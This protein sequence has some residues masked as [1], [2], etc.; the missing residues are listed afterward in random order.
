M[1]C[2]NSLSRVLGPFNRSEPPRYED[3]CSDRRV[4][5]CELN[6]RG[7]SDA[8]PKA[9]N[10]HDWE[11]HKPR[12]S[13]ISLWLASKADELQQPNCCAPVYRH[14]WLTTS[15]AFGFGI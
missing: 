8:R 2:R 6:D 9:R 10:T 3:C 1:V 4:L 12:R 5:S 11:A 13:N 15:E 7:L 14:F